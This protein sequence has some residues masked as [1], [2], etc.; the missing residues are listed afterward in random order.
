MDDIKLKNLILT[1]SLDY[2]NLFPLSSLFA[3]YYV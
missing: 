2:L 1:L 3:N